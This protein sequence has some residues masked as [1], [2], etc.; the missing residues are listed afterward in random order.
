MLQIVPQM[1][2]FLATSP[3]DFRK[4]MDSLISYCKFLGSDPFS[5]TLFI[6]R[7]RSGTT[8]KMLVYDQ[9]G[10]YLIVRRFSEGRLK[11]WPSSN[12]TLTPLAA[13]ELYILLYNGIPYCIASSKNGLSTQAKCYQ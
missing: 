4:G 9:L 2:I 11:W 8:L 1:T 13:R 5:G 7:N 12:S 3:I 6:F 10:F